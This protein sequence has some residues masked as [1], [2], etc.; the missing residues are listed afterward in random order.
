MF[1]S[2]GNSSKPLRTPSTKKVLSG[3]FAS[4]ES[5]RVEFKGDEKGGGDSHE[6][7]R[8]DEELLCMYPGCGF[9]HTWE[10]TF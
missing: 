10:L 8:E 1:A 3:S 2:F 5:H 7:G 9:P 4:S 6:E